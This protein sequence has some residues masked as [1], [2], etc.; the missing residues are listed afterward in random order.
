MVWDGLNLYLYV[1]GNQIASTPQSV[2]PTAAGL[3]IRIGANASGTASNFFNGLVDD[4]RIWNR[5][6]TAQEIKQIY[7]DSLLGYQKTLNRVVEKRNF[8]FYIS[9]N[10][11]VKGIDVR[12]TSKAIIFR[13][14]FIDSGNPASSGTTT[15]SIFELQ[16]DG[17]LRNYDFSTNAFIVGTPVKSTDNM[18][19]QTINNATTATGIW[20]YAINQL[21]A[22]TVGSIYISQ[23]SNS[24]TGGIPQTREFQFGNAQGDDGAFTEFV[25]G[26]GSSTTSITTNRTD[27]TSFWVGSV[28][29]FTSGACKGLSAH[30]SAFSNGTFTVSSALPV[31][32]SR[33]DT[34]LI[35][36]F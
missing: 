8:P 25:V 14:F 4:A 24:V 21:S 3:P 28:I 1:N 9:S 18:K 15:I 36:G 32:P 33:N 16:S 19:H 11:G 13:N 35:F 17:S 27:A 7:L 22:F 5:P 23:V 6:L 20:T 31:A 10:S 26:L 2:D 34:G 12:Q 29:G 30:V